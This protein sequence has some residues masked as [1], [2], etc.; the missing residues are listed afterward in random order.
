MFVARDFTVRFKNRFWQ[1]TAQDAETTGARPGSRVVV[2]R[3]LSGELRFRHRDRYLA[4]EALGTT[5][6][7][8]PAPKPA[9]TTAKP[10]PKPPKPGRDHPW[11]KHSA[12]AP[13]RP[14]PSA[15]AAPPAQ[16][17]PAPSDA[18]PR[19]EHHARDGGS[20]SRPSRRRRRPPRRHPCP[21]RLPTTRS[22]LHAPRPSAPASPPELR[23]ID[24]EALERRRSDPDRLGFLGRHRRSVQP[25]RPVPS[26]TNWQ[27]P[28]NQP[29]DAWPPPRQ[30]PTVHD[31]QPDI[32]TLA[33]PRTFLLRLDMPVP[34][35]KAVACGCSLRVSRALDGRR[36]T[37]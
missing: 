32:S 20:K 36:S 17:T 18:A 19:R 11:R 1:L 13:R 26:W 10:R 2:E 8:A 3:R 37:L 31:H 7:A 25:S 14:S 16:P 34:R 27:G 24:T 29:P 21:R 30:E 35:R 15:S 28:R 23:A 22:S 12:R 9:K 33:K 4:P 5:R 6:P